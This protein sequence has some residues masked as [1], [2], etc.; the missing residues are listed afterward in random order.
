MTEK[1]PEW[2][3]NNSDDATDWDF[4]KFRQWCTTLGAEAFI[5]GGSKGLHTSMHSILM[6][7]FEWQKKNQ[8]R[9][10]KEKKS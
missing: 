1:K 6:C 4:N 8:I 7:A 5:M 9:L 10:A 3:N 2:P